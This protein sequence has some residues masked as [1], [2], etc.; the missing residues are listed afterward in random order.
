M[1]VLQQSGRVLLAKAVAA[2]TIYIA[3]GRGVPAW[4]ANPESEPADAVALVDEIGRR[5]VTDIAFVRPDPA[6]EIEMPGGERFSVAG[7]P[8]SWVRLR[9]TFLFEDARGET[10]REVGVFFDT[11]IA[12]GVPPGQRWVPRADVLDPG[13][14][15]T[16]E[17]RAAEYRSGSVR[18]VE[19]IILPF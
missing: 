11:Q 2:R 16:L 18:T 3:W 5:L 9:A 12:P 17:R 10:V 4:D 19:E 8:T 15:Y 1:P 6:G 13:Q 7:A 14:L